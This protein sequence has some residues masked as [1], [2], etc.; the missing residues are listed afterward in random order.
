MEA[1]TGRVAII[2]GGNSGIGKAIAM[3]FAKEG[4]KVV[5]AA[6]RAEQLKEVEGEIKAAGGTAIGVPT[7]VTK[8]AD[9]LALFD[10]TMKAHGRV[11]VLIN[12]AGVAS[13]EKTD[14]LPLASWQ[15]VIDVNLTGCF[16]CAREAF[17]IMKTQKQGRIINIG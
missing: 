9:V 12:N 1:L 11:D 10:K 7:D 13:R 3:A 4:A 15:R 16:L 14:E 8:E 17:K 6:R 5:L 2:T